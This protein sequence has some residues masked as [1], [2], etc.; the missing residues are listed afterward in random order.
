M[1][2]QFCAQ[3]WVDDIRA[4]YAKDP[5]KAEALIEGYLNERLGNCPPEERVTLMEHIIDEFRPS[6]HQ[7]ASSH[8]PYGALFAQLNA[9]LFGE[10]VQGLDKVS[11]ETVEK[12]G[13]SLN[14]VFDKLNELVGIIKATL[15]GKETGLETIR[16]VIGSELQGSCSSESL[17]CYLDQ[18]KRA[19]L[20]AY[21]A[22]QRAA[23]T[24]VRRIIEEMDPERIEATTDAGLK[25]GPLRKAELFDIYR[26]K[27]QNLKKWFES[28]RFMEEFLREFE[29][30]GKD[31]YTDRREKI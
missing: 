4:L 30:Q 5:T 13:N 26:D 31:I 10:R 21:E 14:T 20:A 25:F 6:D 24:K 8:S 9:L 19:F 2:S 28:G 27:Y 16:H 29:R 3:E 23:S 18:I 7:E 15:L 22:S 12:L 17:E 1:G 11:C